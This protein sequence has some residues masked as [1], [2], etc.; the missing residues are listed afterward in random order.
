MP[1]SVFE[2]KPFYGGWYI[3][4]DGAAHRGVYPTKAIAVRTMH[5]MKQGLIRFEKH[6]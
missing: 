6:E 2:L 4:K 5:K 3:V 1:N